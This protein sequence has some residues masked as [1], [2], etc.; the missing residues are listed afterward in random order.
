MDGYKF[1]PVVIGK[2]QNP[3]CFKDVA[4]EDL[5]VIYF[6]NPSAWVMSEIMNDWIYK[7]FV[8]E[9]KIR[10]GNRKVILFYLY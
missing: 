6:A 2:A 4:K 10:Y 8:S 5:P 3:R 1:E 9:M 7:Y